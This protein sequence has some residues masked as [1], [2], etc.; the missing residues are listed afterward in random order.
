MREYKPISYYIKNNYTTLSCKSLKRNA[1]EAYENND[2]AVRLILNKKNRPQYEIDKNCIDRFTARKRIPKGSK[3]S[4]KVISELIDKS[5]KKFIS[6]VTINFKDSTSKE[7]YKLILE[8][9]FIKTKNDIFYAIEKDVDNNYHIHFAST[10]DKF[11]LK[12]MIDVIVNKDFI[13]NKRICIKVGNNKT[14]APIEIEDLISEENFKEY[15]EK[16]VTVRYLNIIS[17]RW[18]LAT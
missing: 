1:I 14:Y 6:V 17:N 12:N 3:K 5:I 2:N 15:I 8:K 18:I 10:M 16:E 4:K 9:I 7:F 11:Q 13:L